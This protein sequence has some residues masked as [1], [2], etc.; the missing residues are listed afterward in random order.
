MQGGGQ[1]GMATSFFFVTMAT[2]IYFG[3]CLGTIMVT[4]VPNK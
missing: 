3:E 2:V 4:P 1:S